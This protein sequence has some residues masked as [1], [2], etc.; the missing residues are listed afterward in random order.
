MIHICIIYLYNFTYYGF[1][2]KYLPCKAK[3]QLPKM[4]Q[5]LYRTEW[6]FLDWFV[7][8]MMALFKKPKSVTLNNVRWISEHCRRVTDDIVIFLK[9]IV[10]NEE[11]TKTEERRRRQA[12][13]YNVISMRVRV[14]IVA[15]ENQ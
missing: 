12:C 15:V 2:F 5:I 11:N 13:T 3:S 6:D 4:K 7:C 14:T 1:H 10:S 8:L 9:K